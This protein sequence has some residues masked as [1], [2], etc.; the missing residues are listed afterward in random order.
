MSLL[1]LLLGTTELVG[2]LNCISV[3]RDCRQI[4]GTVEYFQESAL[5]RQEQNM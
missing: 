1:L 3:C 4:D 2:E 5:C